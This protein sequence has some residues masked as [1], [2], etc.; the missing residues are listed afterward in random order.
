M[1]KLFFILVALGALVLGSFCWQANAGSAAKLQ[2]A[3]TRFDKPV[4]VHGVVLP[5]GVYLFMHDDI[6][7]M[8]G[9]AC[10]YV[11]KGDAQDNDKLVVSFHCTP[12]ER[13][14]ADSFVVRS[15]EPSPG[16][17][18]LREFQCKGDTEAHLIPTP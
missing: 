1:K 6:A 3:V 8:R 9:D 14:K 15:A 12:A 7:M 2:Q 16:V 11:Y 4:I 13:R 18:V 5:P 10:S 17:V